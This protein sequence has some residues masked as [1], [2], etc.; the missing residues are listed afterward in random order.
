MRQAIRARCIQAVITG[1]LLLLLQGSGFA[2]GDV[3]DSTT[4][5][6]VVVTTNSYD[7]TGEDQERIAPVPDTPVFRAVPDS[8]IQLMQKRREFAYANDPSYWKKEKPSNESSWF[9]W[10]ITR[11]WFRYMVLTVMVS[12]LLFALIKIAVSNR[13]FIFGS[14]GKSGNAEENELLEKHNLAELILQAE[15]QNDFR[16]AI[17]Y[18]Y[19]KVLQDMDERHII[20]LNAQSTNWDYVN[21][22]ASHPLKKQFL[23]LTQAYEYVWYG[24][25]NI[26]SDQYGYV[27]TEFLQFENSLKR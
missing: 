21:T 12:I 13:L 15:A 6:S 3:M 18:R 11:N 23:L 22:M 7:D 16:L 1:M 4:L 5:D 17:R 2:Q 8:V 10:L 27:K 20:Q 24:E 19:M 9:D 14:S 26:N 25:F